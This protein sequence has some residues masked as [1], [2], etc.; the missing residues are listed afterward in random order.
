M[1]LIELLVIAI[2]ISGSF[3]G[4]ESLERLVL[5]EKAKVPL[6][7]LIVDYLDLGLNIRRVNQEQR[8]E[9]KLGTIRV[10]FFASLRKS[11]SDFFGP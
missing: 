2:D 5:V 6:P 4:I 1:L 8:E 10:R 3:L 9:G 11:G 7:I